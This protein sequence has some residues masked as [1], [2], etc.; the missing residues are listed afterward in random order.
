[1]GK[2]DHSDRDPALYLVIWSVNRCK[3]RAFHT[4]RTAISITSV[5]KIHLTY[6]NKGGYHN[7]TTQISIPFSTEIH[8]TDT[9]LLSKHIQINI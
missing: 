6:A 4:D 7:D 8:F 5:A 1:M 9:N 3:L 2:G